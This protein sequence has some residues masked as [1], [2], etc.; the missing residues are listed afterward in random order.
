[1]LCDNALHDLSFITDCSSLRRYR[2]LTNIVDYQLPATIAGLLLIPISST[3]FGRLFRPSSGA[4]EC[5]TAC[6]IMHW[7][8]ACR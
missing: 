4:I 2:F 6:G 1:M 7:Y 8:N 3:R 5:V